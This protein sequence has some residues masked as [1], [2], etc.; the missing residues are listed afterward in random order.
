V[1]FEKIHVE[2]GRFKQSSKLKKVFGRK[3]SP[4]RISNGPPLIK[5]YFFS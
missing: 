1:E 2:K 5:Q 3:I 4:P